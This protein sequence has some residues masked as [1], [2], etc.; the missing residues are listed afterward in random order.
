MNRI[1][2]LVSW[3]VKKELCKN[4]NNETTTKARK[5]E[6]EDKR[7]EIHHILTV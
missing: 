4:A 1:D 7:K 3:R 2:S 5:I 6:I